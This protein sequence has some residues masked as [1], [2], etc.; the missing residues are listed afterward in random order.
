MLASNA[1]TGTTLIKTESAVKF[2]EL[3]SS[4]TSNKESVKNVMKVIPSSTVDAK[5]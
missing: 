3:A 1:Q 2:R 5:E 4:S